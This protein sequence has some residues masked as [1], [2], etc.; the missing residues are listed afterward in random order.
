ML[1]TMFIGSM[2]VFVVLTILYVRACQRL[3]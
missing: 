3:K 1:D 2:V